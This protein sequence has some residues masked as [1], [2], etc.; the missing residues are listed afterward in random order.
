MISKYEIEKAA[1]AR[2]QSYFDLKL[3]KNEKDILLERVK[4]RLTLVIEHY[5]AHDIETLLNLLYRID[6]AEKDVKQALLEEDPAEKLADLI[7]NR[8]LQKAE[9]RIQYQNKK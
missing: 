5:L 4:Q 1:S 2:L 6:V 7:I 8:E 3:I 9:T